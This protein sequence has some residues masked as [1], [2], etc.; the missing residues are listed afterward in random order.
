VA[1][2]IPFGDVTVLNDGSV[3]VPLTIT[4]LDKAKG[5]TVKHTF[6]GYY[7]VGTEGTT[8]QLFSANV[9]QVN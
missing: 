8:W 7:I 1:I 9:H 4:S 6:L 2:A 3:Q 5:G